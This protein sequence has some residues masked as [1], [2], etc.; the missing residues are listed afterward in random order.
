MAKDL[1]KPMATVELDVFGCGKLYLGEG[2]DRVDISSFVTAV[3]VRARS[4]HGTMITVEIPFAAAIAD[5]EVE[6]GDETAKAL[7]ALGWSG[8]DAE[9]LRRRDLQEALGGLGTVLR[10]WSD[11]LEQARLQATFN[12]ELAKEVSRDDEVLTRVAA[13]LG[14]YAPSEVKWS[15]VLE[16][17]TELAGRMEGLE[18]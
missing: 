15:R 9:L 13:A 17:I 18:K 5:G 6:L 1:S 12:G 8:P 16:E 14:R 11:L 7:E 10:E 4:G 3:T 2:D